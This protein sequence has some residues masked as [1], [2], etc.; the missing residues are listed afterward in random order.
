MFAGCSNLKSLE[1][2]SFDTTKVGSME[3][4][5]ASCTS[6][7][8]LNL[9]H[10]KTPNLSEIQDMFYNCSKLAAI[11]MGGFD[12][13]K[14]KA[15]DEFGNAYTPFRKC[16]NLKLLKIPKKNTIARDLPV[17][18]YDQTGKSYTKLPVTSKSLPRL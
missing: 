15:K 1:L 13:S 14:V 4:M 12:L 11:D 6:L 9:Q 16:T 5:F 7:T 10:F 8:H 2:G 17:T 3:G 18:L